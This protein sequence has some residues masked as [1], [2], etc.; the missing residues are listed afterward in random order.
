MPWSYADSS[1]IMKKWADK[2]GI[3]VDIVQIN[4]AAVEAFGRMLS[5]AEKEDAENWQG[6]ANANNRMS[7]FWLP[8]DPLH[9]F[10]SVINSV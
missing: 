7:S 2:Y 8:V 9:S 10:K 5:I 1:G 4:D 6:I 3:E